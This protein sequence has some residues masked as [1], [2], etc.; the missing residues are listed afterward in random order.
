M[1][2]KYVLKSSPGLRW[3]YRR[4]HACEEKGGLFVREQSG[5]CQFEAGYM[6]RMW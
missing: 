5:V 6:W 1:M 3:A 2:T 4:K